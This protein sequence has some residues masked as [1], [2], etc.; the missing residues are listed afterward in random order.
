MLKSVGSLLDNFS[1]PTG[2]D[3]VAEDVGIA[4]KTDAIVFPIAF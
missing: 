2:L 4:E 1:D 3:T